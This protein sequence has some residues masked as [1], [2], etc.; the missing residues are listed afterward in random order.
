VK[1]VRSFNNATEAYF[2]AGLLESLGIPCEV[3]DDDTS[4]TGGLGA[5]LPFSPTVWVRRDE[6]VPLAIK[7][8]DEHVA[9]SAPGWSCPKCGSKNEAPFDACWS[10]RGDRP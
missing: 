9:T 2:A 7:A 10:C 3:H 1:E 5:G 6:D 4:M 8:I